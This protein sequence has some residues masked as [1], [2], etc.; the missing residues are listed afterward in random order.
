M[1]KVTVTGAVVVLVSV[2]LIF[3]L[4]LAGIP[5]TVTKLSRVQLYVVPETLPVIT[6]VVIV[7]P[8]QIV[9]DEGVATTS[10]VG[11]TRTVAVMEFPVQPLAVGVIVKVTVTGALVV[12]VSV[13]LISPLPLDGIPVTVTKLFR[14]Q[15]N[16]VPGR[17]P[18]RTIVVIALPEQIVCEYGVATAFGTGLTVTVTLSEPEHPALSVTV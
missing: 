13:P 15:L 17:F 11:L 6:I 12:F 4:P 16:K 18:V 3:P 10:G 2:P 7:L 1:V 8:E 5:V 9:C 14:V